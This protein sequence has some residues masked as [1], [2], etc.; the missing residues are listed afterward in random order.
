MIPTRTS[1]L[2][3][4]LARRRRRRHRTAWYVVAN[5]HVVLR[6]FP[7][8]GGEPRHILD[9]KIPLEHVLPR[10]RGSAHTR[11]EPRRLARAKAMRQMRSQPM[12]VV[13]LAT[14]CKPAIRE[15]HVPRSHSSDWPAHGAPIP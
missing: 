10:I 12:R 15:P 6:T 4:V 13:H 14:F 5:L 1:S 3:M 7:S 8:L 2:P 11:D 9:Q